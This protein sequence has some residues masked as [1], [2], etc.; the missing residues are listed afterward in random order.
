MCVG[1]SGE[2]MVNRLTGEV[3]CWVILKTSKTKSSKIEASIQHTAFRTEAGCLNTK[4]G[5][6]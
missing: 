4:L 2:Y 1:L 6:L 3:E 5:G